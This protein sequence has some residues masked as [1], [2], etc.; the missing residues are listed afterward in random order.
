M[1]GLFQEFKLAARL[2][3]RSPLLSGVIV[4]TLA[5]G[6]GATTAIFSFVSGVLL[7]PL[8]YPDPYQLVMVCE[9]HPART[10][11][12]CGASPAN[13]A[14]WVR[15]TRS[16]AN[17][18]LARS[19][20]FNI[21]YQEKA[22]AING[23]LATPGLFQTFRAKP[24]L[25]RLIEQQ[26]SLSGNER[27]ALVSHRFWQSTLGGDEDIVGQGITIDGVQHTIIGVLPERFV[28]PD[29]EFVQL[30]V[31]LWP[32]R[33]AEDYR[34]W[35]G[36]NSFARLRPGVSLSAAREEMQAIRNH[37]AEQYPEDDQD[38]GISVESLHERTVRPVRTALLAF[39]V[40]VLLVLLIACANTANL[41]LAHS[42]TRNR[43]FGLRL[44]LGVGRFRLFR[45]VLAESSLYAVTGSLMGIILAFWAV[46]LFVKLAPA[47]FPR[48]DL[49]GV[50]PQ[51]LLFSLFLGIGTTFLF[52]IAP[53]LQAS[54]LNLSDVVRSAQRSTRRQGGG[55]RK[56]LVVGEIGLACLLAV[57]A[58]LFTRSFVQLL[59]WKAGFDPTNLSFAQV[60]VSLEKFSGPAESEDE[61]SVGTR[62]TNLF[63]RAVEELSHLPGV[64]S[65]AGGSAVPLY[66]GDGEQEFRIEGRP[67]VEQGT[68]PVVS[69]FDV[70][71]G[72]F[73]TLKV[74]L[75]DGRLFTLRDREDA[76]PVAIIN[77]TMARRYWPSQSPVGARVYMAT[78][79]VT[80]EIVGVVGD[81]RPFRPDRAPEPQIFWPIA[82]EPRGAIMLLTRSTIDPA[83]LATSFRETLER[84]DPDLDI[85]RVQTM[86]ELMRQQRINPAFNTSLA[87]LFA[88]IAVV[89]ALIG[90][91]GVMSFTVQEQY[92]EFGVRMALGARSRD[93]AL[94]VLKDA[95]RLTA[96]GL[97]LGLAVAWPFSRIVQNL[98]IGI[99]PTDPITYTMIAVGLALAALLASSLPA[100]RASQADPQQLLR[101]Q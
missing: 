75:L 74:P 90:V 97:A 61:S 13:W 83:T 67:P 20:H 25:G 21:R 54:R 14:D 4:V 11:G 96:I 95:V 72:Y 47:W 68:K 42:A 59:D 24:R 81:I 30:W 98:L 28:V 76:P 60:F 3:V 43:E 69:W 87:G 26:D 23:G 5:L 100:R 91:Y 40:A 37:L 55:L 57:E 49:V 52:G 92:A 80:M 86:D 84:L 29:L 31:P 39:S 99:A 79:Q 46:D 94:M 32:E 34:G 17:M 51:V 12:W 1:T 35:R 33:Y 9:T 50:N 45:Q 48:I 88:A 62:I 70:T 53:A 15:S 58:G 19:W 63:M 2:F 85:G 16:F 38:W 78:H 93:I 22:E 71:P 8:D 64:V 10:D 36:L 7:K 66:G 82:Q 6:I 41:L 27:V 56:L 101:C 44:A 18:G 73:E 77:Q 89:I 65:A